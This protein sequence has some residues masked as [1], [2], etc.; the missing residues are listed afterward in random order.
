MCFEKFEAYPRCGHL[1][2]PMGILHPCELFATQGRTCTNEYNKL[3]RDID[4][5]I[6]DEAAKQY[7]EG[8][9][10]PLEGGWKE[11]MA[12]GL[13][14]FCQNCVMGRSEPLNQ[15]QRDEV[16]HHFRDYPQWKQEQERQRKYEARQERWL[17]G[18][19]SSDS[20]TWEDHE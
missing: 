1:K 4:Y 11:A 5:I 16:W 13:K 7:L 15:Q 19:K 6:P 20:D 3:P 9:D 10:K 8:H 12:Q 17:R 14:G 18:L 2:S